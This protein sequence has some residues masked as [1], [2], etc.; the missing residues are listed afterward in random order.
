MAEFTFKRGPV[1]PEQTWRCAD[2]TVSGPNGESISLRDVSE[3]HFLYTPGTTGIAQFGLV[4]AAD[5]IDLQCNARSGSESHVAFASLVSTVLLELDVHNPNV[6]FT[7][8]PKENTIRR[9]GQLVGVLGLIYGI[10]FVVVNGLL[11][12]ESAGLGIGLGLGIIAMSAFWIWSTAPISTEPASL[13]DT[14]QWV[15]RAYGTAI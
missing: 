7:P 4:S 1:M 8:P 5:S 10:Y 3:G 12:E 14:K 6:T 13:A 2:G 11:A 9:V 15:S